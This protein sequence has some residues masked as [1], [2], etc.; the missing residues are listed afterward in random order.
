[1]NWAIG[2]LS[3]AQAWPIP[4]LCLLALSGPCLAQIETANGGITSPRSPA[5]KTRAFTERAENVDKVGLKLTGVIGLSLEDE[6]TIIL[7]LESMR[8]LDERGLGLGDMRVSSKHSLH[9]VDG[10]MTSDRVAVIFDATLP[11]GDSR[12]EGV[13][14][15]AQMGLGTPQLGAGLVYTLIRDRHRFSAEVG[16]RYPF[17]Q[18]LAGSGR[19]NLAYWYRLSPAQFPEDR[20]VTE[21][22][23]VIEVLSE[24]RG[25]EFGNAPG[26]ITWLAPGVQVYP[27][28]TWQLEANL[29][30]PIA[31]SL[32][33]PLGQRRVGG[34]VTAIV[35][36]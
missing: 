20:Q 16:Y 34:G 36:F 27:S 3:R 30:V 7:P 21:I 35:R 13:P 17:G 2:I 18:G 15:R 31:Q 4:L 8:Y 11:T 1:M 12:M 10:V 23:G 33:D 25:A 14:L 9:Q 24:W 19:T 32:R 26:N 6:L 22:R 28:R 29:L 5:L